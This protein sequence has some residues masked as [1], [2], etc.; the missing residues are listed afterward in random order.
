MPYIVLV[1]R[2]TA[3]KSLINRHARSGTGIVTHPNMIQMNTDGLLVVRIDYQAADIP[4]SVHATHPVLYR[5]GEGYCC[6]LGPDEARGI[7]GRG[8][9]EKAA[10]NDFDLQF[11]QRLDHPIPGDP[12]SE[13]IQHRHV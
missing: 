2:P 13:F 9:T 6:L 1:R 7:I 10:L 4:E 12:V 8:A 3:G 11:Q 5:Q